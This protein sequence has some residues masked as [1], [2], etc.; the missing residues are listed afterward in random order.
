VG[1]SRGDFTL[2][3]SRPL[4]AAPGLRGGG[5]SSGHG[6]GTKGV[7]SGRR[8]GLSG[9]RAVRSSR[10]GGSSG[11]FGEAGRP[12][13]G[14]SLTFS[15][16]SRTARLEGPQATASVLGVRMLRTKGSVGNGAGATFTPEA[17]VANRERRLVGEGDRGLDSSVLDVAKRAPT[18]RGPRSPAP[19]SDTV[20]GTKGGGHA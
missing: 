11:A 17:S 5:S 1:A 14:P 6:G 7:A 18:R 4:L 2:G 16:R 9:G 12:E 15:V 19:R 8:R 13:E 20:S 3:L 10:A